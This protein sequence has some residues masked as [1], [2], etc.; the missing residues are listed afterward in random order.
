[1]PNGRLAALFANSSN[2]ELK[3]TDDDSKVIS[4]LNKQAKAAFDNT[5]RLIT[6]RIDKFGVA[7]PG[8]NPDAEKQIISVELPGVQDRERVKKNL[9]ASANL[10]FWEVYN[11][12]EIWPNVQ[13]ADELFFSGNGGKVAADSTASKDTTAVASAATDT[14]KTTATAKTDTGNLQAQLKDLAKKMLPKQMQEL[15]TRKLR[16]KTFIWLDWLLG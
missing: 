10:Q 11:I 14:A 2:T 4:Y 3:A 6:T 5:A 8:I 1:M 12:S 13:K 7:Q 16:L 15:P 9:Q